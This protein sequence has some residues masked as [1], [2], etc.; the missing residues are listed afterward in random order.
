MEI[1][2]IPVHLG[3]IAL[4]TAVAFGI[5]MIWHSLL[6]GRQWL[7][8]QRFSEAQKKEL[9]NNMQV[10]MIVSIFGYLTTAIVMSLLFGYM[11]VTDFSKALTMTFLLWLGFPFVMGLTGTLY[12]GRSLKGFLIDAGYHLAYLS[13]MAVI[14]VTLK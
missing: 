11:N 8:E 2:G 1:M 13:A 9:G 5:G 7:E 10:P 6:F 12:G 3:A 4:S 14:L